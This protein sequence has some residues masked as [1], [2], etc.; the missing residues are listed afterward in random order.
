MSNKNHNSTQAKRPLIDRHP[1]L[2]NV[3]IIIIVAVLGICIA[4]LSLGLFTKH[5]RSKEVPSVELSNYSD[6][7]K[8]LN[9]AG[10]KTE[11]RDSV[12]R[13][14]VRPGLVV[15]Q[16]P[17]PGSMVKPG[18]KVFLYINAVHPKEVVIDDDPHPLDNALKSFSL[19]QGIA[20]LEELGFKNIKVVKVLGHDDCIVKVIANGRTVKKTQKVPINAQIIIEVSDGRLNELRD[21]LQNAEYQLLNPSQDY[22][23]GDEY[24][25]ES[26]FPSYSP[27]QSEYEEPVE[28]GQNEEELYIGE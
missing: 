21:S 11:I 24:V 28:P 7:I 26:G 10:F 1:V 6:A 17:R 8:K 13:D 20:R 14:D 15:E 16:F 2:V 23:V 25:D 12:Y 5:G 22:G 3:V 4:Y 27:S 9:D 19:R 18:R